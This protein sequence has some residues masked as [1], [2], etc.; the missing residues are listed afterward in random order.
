MWKTYK[1][2]E[3]YA[4][5]RDATDVEVPVIREGM[6]MVSSNPDETPLMELTYAL[7]DAARE[8]VSRYADIS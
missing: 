3:I 8:V 1:L 7:D 5:L 4:G 2:R 6:K